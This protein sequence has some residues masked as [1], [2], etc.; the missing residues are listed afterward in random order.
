[1]TPHRSSDFPT[2]AAA[3]SPFR[4]LGAQLRRSSAWSGSSSD[5]LRASV[6]HAAEY[7]ALHGAALA[8]F[9]AALESTVSIHSTELDDALRER[10]RATVL[11]LGRRAFESTSDEQRGDRAAPAD[12]AS[13]PEG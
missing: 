5:E 11:H 9:M 12:A 10:L 7:A 2:G 3:E 13:R 6:W 4:L 1:M 8:D